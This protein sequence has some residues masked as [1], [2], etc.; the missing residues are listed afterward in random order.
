MSFKVVPLGSDTL[1]LT[2]VK[3][4]KAFVQTIFDTPVSALNA[5][6]VTSSAFVNCHPSRT[7]FSCR[8]NKK[9]GSDQVQGIWQMLQSYHFVFGKVLFDHQQPMCRC[10][11][12]RKMQLVLCP[13][14]WT[15]PLIASLKQQRILMYISFFI[16]FPSGI[17]L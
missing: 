10:V 1:F 13:F 2:F 5:F 12:V 17:N 15:F 16:V 14:C 7:I 3:L 8:N 9:S 11:I 6:A 4:L